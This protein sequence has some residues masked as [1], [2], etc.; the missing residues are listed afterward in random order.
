MVMNIS[1][2]GKGLPA[3]MFRLWL[4][5]MKIVQVCVQSGQESFTTQG[6]GRWVKRS[7]SRFNGAACLLGDS[8]YGILQW[9]ITP[10]KPPHNAAER[11]FNV[12]HARE[13]VIVDRFFGQLK[14]DFQFWQ[15]LSKYLKKKYRKS[16]SAVLFSIIL[17]ST[18]MMH[19]MMMKRDCSATRK[20]KIH[21]NKTK[22]QQQ[23]SEDNKKG[24]KWWNL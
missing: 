18:L 12:N 24:E 2:T 5:Q 21:R 1:T 14:E 15:T 23:H 20:K 11:N 6:F 9:L 3:L 7:I 22:L 19:L 13:R 10:F 17:E 4:M 8:G 16:L